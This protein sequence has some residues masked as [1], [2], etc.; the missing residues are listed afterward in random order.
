MAI[1]AVFPHPKV[2]YLTEYKQLQHKI[3]CQRYQTSTEFRQIFLLAIDNQ[4]YFSGD[5]EE[6]FNRL[7]TH[8]EKH[9]IF[10]TRNNQSVTLKKIHQQKQIPSNL[11]SNSAFADFY[12]M[13]DDNKKI[14]IRLDT[15]NNALCPFSQKFPI[16]PLL[17]PD[18]STYSDNIFHDSTAT[19]TN[20]SSISLNQFKPNHALL[21]LMHAAF[22]NPKKI[23]IPAK[24]KAQL[25]E[26]FSQLK[27]Q[28]QKELLNIEKRLNSLR[29][30][31]CFMYVLLA[32]I[33]LSET[34]GNP[35]LEF[36]LLSLI[37]L[38][39]VVSGV[40]YLRESQQ[41]LTPQISFLNSRLA[42]MGN[43]ETSCKGFFSNPLPKFSLSETANSRSPHLIENLMQYSKKNS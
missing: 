22:L 32:V 27:L 15:E 2:N 36:S 37:G 23:S 39:I 18:G 30:Q 6:T 33:L 35:M 5:I 28:Y 21:L 13:L 25:K 34:Y 9:I 24:I 40:A 11:I 12:L 20:P 42:Q 3:N 14:I 31:E 41:N 17:A 38:P 16:F 10:K 8:E 19:N 4:T 43:L 29:N 7:L 1:Q 26:N